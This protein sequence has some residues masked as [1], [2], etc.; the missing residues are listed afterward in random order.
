[1]E[2]LNQISDIDI[3]QRIV[4]GDK[5]LFEIIVRRYN[6][7]LYKIGRSYNY[8]HE[9]TEDLMQESYIDSFKNLHQ[10]EQRS[11]FKT[12]L[13]KI[14]LNNCYRKKQ[15]LSY[16]NEVSKDINSENI[17]PLF[18]T[19]NI[20]AQ[21]SIQNKELA[22]VI[23]HSVAQLPEDYRL[24]FS[25]REISGMNVAETAALLNISESNVKVRLN[26]AKTML[27]KEIE[28]SYAPQELFDYSLRYCNPFT[29]KIMKLIHQL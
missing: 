1:M 20:E 16:R 14:M 12:W 7:Y 24:V 19:S 26:R 10:F 4:Q 5:A 27:R 22:T 17:K 8:N 9:D 3:I 29:E 6:P 28:K 21:M 13:I 23:E 2:T 18:T 15:K 25:L 11:N